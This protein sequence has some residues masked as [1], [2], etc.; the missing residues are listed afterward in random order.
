MLKFS[1][2][3]R[4]KGGAWPRGPPDPS[5]VSLL[6]AIRH[7]PEERPPHDCF[8][9]GQAVLLLHYSDISIIL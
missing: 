2:I 1:P 8:G 9:Q 7:R 4:Y 6:P 5:L 3:F